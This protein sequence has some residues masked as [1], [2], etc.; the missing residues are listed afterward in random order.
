GLLKAR[1]ARTHA[2]FAGWLEGYGDGRDDLAPLLG[3]HYAEAARPEHADLAWAGEDA[4]LENLRE[5]A[6]H[7]LR[8]AAVLGIRRYDIDEGVR[9]LGRALELASDAAVR[10]QLWREI[11]LANV[12]KYDGEAFVTAMQA[13]LELCADPTACGAGYALLAYHTASRSGMWTQGVD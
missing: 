8:R 2:G 12:L 3:H 10:S 6:V 5:K 11:G 4:T 13:S 7:W 1:R 9:F